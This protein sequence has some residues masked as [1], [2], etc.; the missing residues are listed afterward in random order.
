M[1]WSFNDVTEEFENEIGDS[2]V[3]DESVDERC[4]VDGE[5]MTEHFKID[6]PNTSTHGSFDDRVELV[7]PLNPT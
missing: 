5:P 1:T 3:G 6:T 7:A 2:E 4:N